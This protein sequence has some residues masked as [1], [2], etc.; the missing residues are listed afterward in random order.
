M[1]YKKN[2]RSPNYGRI[3]AYDA[4]GR[5][6]ESLDVLKLRVMQD[7]K[8]FTVAQLLQSVIELKEQVANQEGRL[9]VL[10]NT[11]KKVD[12]LAKLAVLLDIK[13]KNL[14]LK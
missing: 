1:D 8:E 3:F 9:E 2:V 14:E 7:G 4:Q 12:T 6:I 10:E 11:A 5:E 13:I